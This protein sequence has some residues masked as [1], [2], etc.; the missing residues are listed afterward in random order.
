MD[1]TLCKTMKPIPYILFL[2]L[3]LFCT[4][5]LDARSD[6]AQDLVVEAWVLDRDQL[7]A[8]VGQPDQWEPHLRTMRELNNVTRFIGVRIRNIGSVPLGGI[9]DIREGD[10]D[11]F[12]NLVGF[13]YLSPNPDMP[14]IA[15]LAMGRNY[16]PRNDHPLPV[17]WTWKSL[18]PIKEVQP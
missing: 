6:F 12:P 8:F 14:T 3:H 17:F 11:D 10:T 2:L 13:E 9:L 16:W 4:S 18:K 7:P 15:V 1:K 5:Y